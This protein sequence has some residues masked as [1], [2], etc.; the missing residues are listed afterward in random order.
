[1]VTRI[2]MHCLRM[3]CLEQVIYAQ[4]NFVMDV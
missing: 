4:L 2:V 3:H 1:M